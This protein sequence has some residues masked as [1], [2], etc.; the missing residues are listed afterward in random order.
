MAELFNP[1]PEVSDREPADDTDLFGY[2][3]D[4]FEE[5]SFEGDD[6]DVEITYDLVDLD[7]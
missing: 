5:P 1:D 3:D 2:D 7:A 6:F 4:M